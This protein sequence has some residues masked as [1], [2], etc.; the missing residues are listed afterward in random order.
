MSRLR[1]S[2]LC[3][4]HWRSYRKPIPQRIELFRN[5]EFRNQALCKEN[6]KLRTEKASAILARAADT[7]QRVVVS[8]LVIA[9]AGSD[10]SSSR[11]IPSKLDCFRDAAGGGAAGAA[12]RN[13]RDRRLGE[14]S[15]GKPRAGVFAGLHLRDSLVCRHLLLDLRHDASVWRAEPRGGTAGVA[16]VLSLP[17]ALSRAIRIAAE[18]AGRASTGQPAG[19]GGRSLSLGNGIACAHAPRA[20][21]LELARHCA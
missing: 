11:F 16:S 1:L 21:S 15:S 4:I 20:G 18:L 2:S 8:G 17:W 19:S 9:S 6:R 3:E 13:A 7:S 5:D 14:T 12:R 10:L